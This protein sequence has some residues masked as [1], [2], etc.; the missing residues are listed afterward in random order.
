MLIGPVF[1]REITI[2][3]RRDWTYIIR[4][5][6][7]GL[8]LLLIVTAWLVVSGTQLITDP[9]DFARFG[10]M[11]FQFLAPIQLV[12]AIFFAATL[13][14]GAVGQEKERKTLLL[15][16]LTR[17]SNS[18]LVLGKLFAGLLNI[19]MMLAVSVP[20]FMAIAML[21]GVSYYQIVRVML[22]T[23]FSMLACGSLGSCVALWRE[24]T[25]Q[26]IATTILVLVLWIGVWETIAISV[27]NGLNFAVLFSPWSAV[28]VASR[29]A[30]D[31]STISIETILGPI[32]N[33]LI[34]CGCL[35]VSI[36][37]VAIALVRVWNPSRE[38]RPAAMEED[39]WHKKNV[40]QTLAESLTVDAVSKFEEN[41]W[42]HQL[43]AREHRKNQIQNDVAYKNG[44]VNITD[45]SEPEQV[46]DGQNQ[47]GQNQQGQNQQ[48]RDQQE[49]DR[50]G[51]VRHTWNNPII[52]REIMTRAYGHRIWVIQFGFLAFFVI[53]AWTLHN[54]LT[55]SMAITVTQLAGPLVPLFLLSLV[56]VNV[57]AITSQTSEKDG[58][59][60]DLILVSDITPKEYV[61]G[62]LGGIFYNMKW[63]VLLPLFLCGYLYWYR[64]LDETL[65][66]F[67][68][69]G[70]TVLYLFVAMV[71][72]YIGMQYDN[73]RAATATSLGVIFFLFVGIAA[74]IWIMVAFSGSFETQLVPFSA[75]MVGG[76]IGLYV[77]LG[78]RNP[79]AAI[80][81][82]S[83]SLPI[84]VFYIITSMLL[85]KYLLVFAVLVGIFGFTTAAMLIPSIAEFDVATGR[86]TAD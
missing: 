71:G 76:G 32:R 49:R 62:K 73:T 41:Q 16:L 81:T 86:T 37:A 28:V 20:V 21:G 70:L 12:L 43:T 85:G 75:F 50:Q 48:G 23:L 6:Y 33:F 84:A 57:Q 11:L 30:I 66:F 78:A 15:L 69:V 55:E 18:E 17:M 58:G 9:G 47:Q 7:V 79:S 36:N 46:H 29:P 10:S 72:V 74:C 14:A 39:T 59:T 42:T 27:P 34:I 35:V 40:E 45:F 3:P 25:F 60:F 24:K 44:V 56:L 83:F 5:V 1:T 65:L 19:L 52:W 8:L 63:I 68:L 51:R 80:A 61:F 67:L 64:A 53:C 2:A 13:V 38:T 77:T 31:V 4:S 22:V 82:A 54:V 26:A